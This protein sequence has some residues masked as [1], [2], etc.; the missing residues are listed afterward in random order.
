MY[1]LA[2]GNHWEQNLKYTVEKLS[3]N[4]VGGTLTLHA[5][6]LDSITSI[7]Y[8]PESHQE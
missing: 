7:P 2:K 4:T 8:D 6:D 5:V 1:Q 3:D